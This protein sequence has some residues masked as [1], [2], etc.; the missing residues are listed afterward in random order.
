MGNT[1]IIAEKPSMARAIKEVVGGAYQV[2]N[3]FGHILEQD[4][5]ESY[6]PNTPV[7]PTT[8]KKLWRIEDLPILPEAWK[9]HPI[10]GSAAQLKI[11]QGL[12]NDAT[13]VINAG[14]PDREGQLLIDEILIYCGY[15]G[16]VQ[17][18]WLASLDAASIQKAFANLKDNRQYAPLSAAAEARSQADWLFGMN[19]T[20]AVSI[21]NNAMFSIGRVQTPTLAL[22]VRRDLEIEHFKARD[23]FEVFAHCRHANGAFAAIWKP[24]SMDGPGF[25]EEGRLISREMADRIAAK[26][27][28]PGRVSHFEKKEQHQAAPLPFSLSALQKA[29]SGK[30]GM[31]AKVVL[32]TCQS[33][34]EKKLTTYP[35]TDCRYLPTEQWGA[36]AGILRDLPIPLSADASANALSGMDLDPTRKHA[37]WNTAKITAHHAIIPTGETASGLSDKEAKLYALVWKSYVALF[38]P[39]YRYYAIS[40]GVDLNGEAWTA[41][42]RT[43]IAPGWKTLYGADGSGAVDTDE[44]DEQG[45][46]PDLRVGDPVHGE[47]G[48]VRE[49]R[50]KP[51]AR[52]T[53]GT[54][55]DAMSNIHKFVEDP[56][57]RAKLKETAGLGTEA[58]RANILETL[59]K[60]DYLSRD[61]K[62]VLSTEKGRSLVLFLEKHLPALVDPVI[63][64]QWEGHLDRIADGKLEPDRFSQAIRQTVRQYTDDLIHKSAGQLSGGRAAA[65][66]APCPMEGCGG[67]VRRL[68]SK[69]RKGSF[70]WACSNKDAHGLLT[71]EDGKPGKPFEDKPKVDPATAMGPVCPKCKKPTF[72]NKT[73]G[74]ADYFRC[75]SCKAA[76]WPDKADTAA[77]GEKWKDKK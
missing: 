37:A 49:K 28:G 9:K 69:S 71:D 22:V 59:F 19:F 52:F 68:E 11:I 66:T 18:V 41:S 10:A 24:V 45:G 8:G 75:G 31:S 30:Y 42:G 76:W 64:A 73:K 77:L 4:D 72:T 56:E 51:P 44:E 34:Y 43:D 7:N 53:D 15:R 3:A 62:K 14:D 47:R 60:R 33:L 54:L 12:L 25:D 38:L 46:L 27:E 39:D 35:R 48:E 32:E 20:R 1:L 6:L 29:A 13:D 55:I 17:R 2:T 57:A 21:T 67:S 40:I 63:T 36:A 16:P 65:V 70:F 74:G 23:Y 58:T 61:G 5:P 50:T 26:A